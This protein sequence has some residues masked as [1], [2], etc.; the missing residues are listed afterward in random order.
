MRIAA[1]SSVTSIPTGH[2]VMQRPQPTHP[3]VPNW[4]IHDEN[5]W[6]S[7]WRYRDFADDRTSPND[8]WEN[9]SLKQLAHSRSR[10]AW[11]PSSEIWSV[12]S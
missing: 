10:V 11:V 12:R 7:H 1:I 9:S 5:L 4:S 6:V 3:L 8:M 2:Q